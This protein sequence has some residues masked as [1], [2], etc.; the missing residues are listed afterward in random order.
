MF[1]PFFLPT[2][3]GAIHA[4]HL[5][6][7]GSS[8]R[9]TLLWLPPF[10]EEANCARRHIVAAARECQL[11]GY[12]SLLIDPFGTGESAGELVDASWDL[13]RNNVVDA[14]NWTRQQHAAP[15]WLAG[16][17]AG[18]LLAADVVSEIEPAGM[19]CWQPVSAG[20]MVLDNFLR[21]K[22]AS[23]WAQGEAAT[24]TDI[25]GRLREQLSSGASV[26][27]A[28]YELS[29]GMAAT[30]AERTLSWARASCSRLACL[31]FRT[32]IDG[33]VVL[34]HTPAMS[35]LCDGFRSAGMLVNS[36]VC[37]APPFWQAHEASL[38]AGLGRA[39]AAL[40]AEFGD[41]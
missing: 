17:R 22:L 15:L 32:H 18:A 38:T 8:L 2:A 36:V 27:V 26:E 25:L 3:C 9:G 37:E 34:Q 12:A 33:P 7:A 1:V 28:G 4:L 20:R 13:W 10:A 21:M 31:E 40:L 35:R 23:E 24:A 41:V 6:H 29:A 14:A 11:L 39:T 30:L 16:V 19:I 5:P